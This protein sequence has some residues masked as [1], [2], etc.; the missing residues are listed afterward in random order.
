M[1]YVASSPTVPAPSRP[2]CLVPF[3]A[4]SRAATSW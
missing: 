1:T 4:P 3:P 2:C